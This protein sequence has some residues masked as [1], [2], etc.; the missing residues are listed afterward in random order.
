MDK[1][2]P[3]ARGLIAV[4]KIGGKVIFLDPVSYATTARPR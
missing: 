2:A 3:N 1:N 4:D